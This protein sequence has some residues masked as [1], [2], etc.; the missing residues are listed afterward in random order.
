MGDGRQ[1]RDMIYVQDVVNANIR[2]MEHDGDLRGEVFNVSTNHSLYIN[3]MHKKIADLMNFEF[4]PEFIPFPEGNIVDSRGD[5]SRAKE[6]LGF[7]IE[8]DLEEGLK[9]TIDW[10]RSEM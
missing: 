8:F 9:R 4:K 5:N 10:Y 6:I 7:S 2:A 1:T 3:E